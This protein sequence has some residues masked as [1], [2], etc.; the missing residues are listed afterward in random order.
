MKSPST[1]RGV[2]LSALALA[3]FL[4]GSSGVGAANAKSSLEQARS[5]YRLAVSQH[6][7]SSR[8]A[9]SARRDLRAARQRF[10]AERRQ[11]MRARQLAAASAAPR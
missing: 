9:Q 5:G 8:E 2:A 6:G 1:R 11:H 3:A 4:A 7:R 10:N